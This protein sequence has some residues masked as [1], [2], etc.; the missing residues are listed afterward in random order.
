MD[1][2]KED[3]VALLMCVA[4]DGHHSY[5]WRRNGCDLLGE[6]YP[7]LYTSIVG[8]YTCCVTGKEQS[9]KLL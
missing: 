6:V 5:Q 7:L 9:V 3:Y 8:T 1:V 4:L 2:S